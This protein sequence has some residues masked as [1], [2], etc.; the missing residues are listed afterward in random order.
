M[1]A[2]KGGITTLKVAMPF[3]HPYNKTD[4]PSGTT[5]GGL[6]VVVVVV[7]VVVAGAC[8]CVDVVATLVVVAAGGP[9]RGEHCGAH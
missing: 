7:V 9:T 5:N 1:P 2:G 4:I 6:G 8:A 3:Q